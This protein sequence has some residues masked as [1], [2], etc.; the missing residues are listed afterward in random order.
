MTMNIVLWDVTRRSPVAAHPRSRHAV[1]SSE[2]SPNVYRT[3]QLHITDESTFQMYI[4]H[5]NPS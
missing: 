2:T 5:L 1:R 3:T 4:S